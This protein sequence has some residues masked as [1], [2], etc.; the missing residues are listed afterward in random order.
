MTL[1]RVDPKWYFVGSIEKMGCN[2]GSLMIPSKTSLC[3][4]FVLMLVCLAGSASAQFTNST[5]DEPIKLSAEFQLEKGKST[6]K[7][8][9]T[10][11]IPEKHYVYSLTQKKGPPAT[12]L[13][14]AESKQFK[15]GAF[16]PTKKPTVIENDE[17]FNCRIEKHYGKIVFVAPI[18]VASGVEPK[19]VEV[20]ISVTGQVCSEENCTPFSNKKAVAKFSGYYEKPQTKK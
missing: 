3:M 17:L 15:L 20:S 13:K 14:I 12:K 8:I 6:G 10:A 7:L 2:L 16:K 11:K 19:N 4:S 18:T 9:L 1:S 5:S